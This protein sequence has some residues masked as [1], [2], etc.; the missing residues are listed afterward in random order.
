MN[1]LL[2]GASG[3]VG[4]E[5]INTCPNNIRLISFDKY[6]LNISDREKALE[7]VNTYKPDIIINCAAYTAV[8]LAETDKETAFQVNANG[9]SNL[10][11]AASK[12][13]IRLIHYST[14]Y[15]FDGKKTS[16]YTTRDKPNP[17]NIYGKSKLEGERQA[18]NINRNKVLII[19]T[20]WVYSK[21]GKNFV[22]SML[23]LMNKNKSIKVIMD[24]TGTPTWARSIANI[25]WEFVKRQETNG[26]V[27]FCDGGS[28]NWFE[29]AKA[30][31]EQALKYNIIN[32]PLKI[33]PITSKEYQSKVK[34]P[35]YSVLDC[36]KTWNLLDI[37]PE[38]WHVN[39]KRMLAEYS[40]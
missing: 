30:I 23:N 27:H 1:V 29:F 22:K 16:P 38:D 28:T 10:A 14:D 17:A 25:T 13:N 31:H 34:R 32:H 15:I 6:A 33:I 24:Q 18:L 8:D 4:H 35:A 26:I 7:I 20:S 37:E 9:V 2:T 40:L 11:L 39:L 21:Y 19:R 5:L 36:D 3:Q 12:N